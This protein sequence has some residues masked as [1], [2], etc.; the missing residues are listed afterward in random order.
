MLQTVMR[1]SIDS[2]RIASPAYSI[3]WPV[4]PA[5]PVSP[6]IDRM[7][8]FAV[9]PAGNFPSTVTR[10]ILGLALDQRLGCEHVL[11]FRRADAMGER[12]ERAVGR[13]VAV[14]AHDR[15][16]GQGEALLG[17]DHVNDALALV[18]LVEIFDAEIARV[19]GELLDLDG[20]FRILDPMRA[21]RGRHVVIHDR[22]CLAGLAHLAAR[23]AKA[24]EGLRAR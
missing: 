3:T 14:A 22:Q 12:A 24:L 11:D 9:T 2:E 10:I 17:P 16:A 18:E 19:L 23:Q 21:I 20:R 13:G 15:H 7:M 5:V 6:M 8:S 4:P 1:P